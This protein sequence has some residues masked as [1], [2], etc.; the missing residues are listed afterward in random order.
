ME[1]RKKIKDMI[2]IIEASHS[3]KDTLCNMFLDHIT[4]HPEYISHGEIQMGVG[5]GKLVNEVFV[6]EV[7][8]MARHYWMKYIDMNINGD[9]SVVYKAV[10]DSDMVVGF[11]IATYTEDGASPFG[12][13]SDIMVKEG[14]RGGGI[15]SELLKTAI[16]WLNKNG[17]HDI[18]LESGLN[19]H[20]AHE[21][22]K[23]KGFRKVSEIYKLM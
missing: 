9:D 11:C 12:M 5:I 19:N 13:I 21:Y 16:G 20:S 7:S 1:E 14:Q 6:T 17:I 3:D 8:P 23:H 2:K 10:D 22:F 18:Y 4:A 15:G